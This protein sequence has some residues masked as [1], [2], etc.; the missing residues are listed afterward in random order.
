MNRGAPGEKMARVG[1]GGWVGGWVS[2]GRG[3][4][5]SGKD[6][7]CIVLYVHAR[8]D[9]VTYVHTH[10]FLQLHMYTYIHDSC[11]TLCRQRLFLFSFLFVVG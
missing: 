11:T 1:P 2:G 7:H 9:V 5:S 8:W 3:K 6:E 10:A 4:E